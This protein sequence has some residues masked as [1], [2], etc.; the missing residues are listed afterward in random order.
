[1]DVAAGVAVGDIPVAVGGDVH[2]GHGDAGFAVFVLH[3]EVVG[4]DGG[5]DVQDLFAVEGELEDV[6]A[7]EA[8]AVDEFAVGL[9]LDDKAVEISRG[10]GDV[11]EPLAVRAIDLQA[12]LRVHGADIYFAR[13]TDGDVA[14]LIAELGAAL[15][16]FQPVG[17]GLVFDGSGLV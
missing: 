10:V 17:D 13:G 2:A 14:M 11:A 3:L 6:A 15:G 9:F 5:R 8:G 4:D 12:G 7:A 1:M 16:Q